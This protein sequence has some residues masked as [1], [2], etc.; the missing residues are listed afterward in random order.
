MKKLFPTLLYSRN[1]NMN[2]FSVFAF[3]RNHTQGSK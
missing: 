2:K 3:F 1:T